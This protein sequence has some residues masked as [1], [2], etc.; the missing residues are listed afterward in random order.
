MFTVNING[1]AHMD[2]INKMYPDNVFIYS[3]TGGLMKMQCVM[4]VLA[5]EEVGSCSLHGVTRGKV[6]GSLNY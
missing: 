6:R 5:H 4:H 1:N 2:H 3:R